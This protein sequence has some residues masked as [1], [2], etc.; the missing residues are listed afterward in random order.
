LRQVIG[1]P[2]GRRAATN[3]AAAAPIA[4]RSGSTSPEHASFTDNTCGRVSLITST[5]LAMTRSPVKQSTMPLWQMLSCSTLIVAGAG[6]RTSVALVAGPTTRLAS[7][8]AATAA[9]PL[10]TDPSLA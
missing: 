6:S 4:R 2:S 5:D 10:F 3:V 7:N 1:E 8:T 9:A